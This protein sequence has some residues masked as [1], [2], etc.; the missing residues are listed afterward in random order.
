MA[1][2]RQHQTSGGKT[3]TSGTT[4]TLALS[5]GVGEIIYVAVALATTSGSVSSITDTGGNTYDRITT[6]TSGGTEKTEF[7]KSRTALASGTLTVTVSGT[8]FRVTAVAASY[9]GVAYGAEVVN[10]ATGSTSPITTGTVTLRESADFLLMA[11]GEA[12]NNTFTA[13]NGIIVGQQGTTSL[14]AILIEQTGGTSLTNSATMTATSWAIVYVT[15]RALTVTADQLVMSDFAP[16]LNLNYTLLINQSLNNWA[17]VVTL[18]AGAGLTLTLSDTLN[19]WA[20]FVQAGYGAATSDQLIISD[21]IGAGY[22]GSLSD[23]LNNWADVF[24]YFETGTGLTLVLTDSLNFWADRLL[25]GYGS[26]TSDQLIISDSLGAGYG[27]QLSDSLNNWQDTAAELLSIA[28]ILSDSLNFWR[29]LIPAFQSTLNLGITEVITFADA[30]G[31]GY[32][33]IV[34]DTLNNWAD[35]FGFAGGVLQPFSDSLNNWADFTGAGYGNLHSDQL[36]IADSLGSGYGAILSDSLNNWQD[37]LVEVLSGGGVIQYSFSED[38]NNWEDLVW[39]GYG[40]LHSD[41]LVISESTGA[42][43]GGLLEDD[44]N[45]WQD[46]MPAFEVEYDINI[47]DLFA[48]SDAMLAGYGNL[49]SDQ[50]I[51][52][53]SLGSGYGAVLSDSLNNWQD[54]FTEELLGALIQLSFADDLNNWTDLM[55][56]GYGSGISEQLI[57]A[58]S[59][60]AGYGGR[61]ADQMSLADAE[62]TTMSFEVRITQ[63]MNA[64]QELM[65]AGYGNQFSDQLIITDSSGAGYGAVLSDTMNFWQDAFSKVLFGAQI[66]ISFSDTLNTWQDLAGAGY[67]SA[68]SDQII[69]A[70]SLGSGYGAVLSDSLNNWSDHLSEQLSIA[71]TLSDNLNNWTDRVLAGYGNLFSDQIVISDSIGQGYGGSLSDSLNNWTEQ[72]GVGYGFLVVDSASGSWKDSIVN[73]LSLLIMLQDQ[74]TTWADSI[75]MMAGTGIGLSDQFTMT[76][77]LGAGYGNALVDEIQWA[78]QQGLGYGLLVTDDLDFWLDATGG[79]GLV[80]PIVITIQDSLTTWQDALTYYLTTNRGEAI[81]SLKVYNKYVAM[82]VV[83]EQA[84]T[85]TVEVVDSIAQT[86]TQQ[87]GSPIV[88]LEIQAVDTLSFWMEAVASGW[89]LEFS[90]TMTFVDGGQVILESNSQ[91]VMGVSDSLNFWSDLVAGSLQ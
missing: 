80:T 74:D 68:M 18:P 46:F 91:F 69:I 82:T 43:Y 57:I 67:G 62:Q 13:Q 8:G 59:L 27:G 16:A 51:L 89:L 70:D 23:N 34:A 50:I 40:N 31:L 90:D 42:G 24:A 25:A 75:A 37:N 76:D 33:D 32:G 4:F 55:L 1:I 44:L 41:Q 84:A 20:D 56:A 17:D 77:A 39:A 73:T 28:V 66:Q 54:A 71:I 53:D 48:L 72:A 38:L 79:G 12:A 35:A 29:D 52:V 45:N 61:L 85:A 7:W 86:W 60:G 2:A 47:T 78:D 83:I 11:G 36:I 5:S 26:L 15:L 6:V 30:L 9:S 22:G 64:W 14:R 10:T 63:S 65:L 19:N 88:P 58:D 21:S 87:L 3:T 49:H 81:A